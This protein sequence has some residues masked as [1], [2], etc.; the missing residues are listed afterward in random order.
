MVTVG[1]FVLYL[2]EIWRQVFRA[3]FR[4]RELFQQLES[5]GNQSLPII[6]LTGFFTGAVF[7]LQIGGIFMIFRAESLMGGA[8]A[9]ALATELAP[10]IVAFLLIGRVGA[11]MT[12]EISTM[13]VQEQVLALE[14]MAV[15]PI[16]YLVVPRVLASMIMMP[17]LC[18]VFMAVGVF[19]AL[20]IALGLYEVDQGIFFERVTGMVTSHDLVVGLRKM[21]IFSFFIAAI[22]CRRG[23]CASGG[24]KG[25]G[26]AT[27]TAVVTSLLMILCIDFLISYFQIRWIS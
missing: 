14:A 22:C 26:L 18:G 17:L 12:A 27:T 9:I 10:L 20:V 1:S 7:G 16:H 24:A 6:V 21:L 4:V 8:T 11:A 2:G 25:V 23:L 3:P 13:V 5:I 15:Q 19:G